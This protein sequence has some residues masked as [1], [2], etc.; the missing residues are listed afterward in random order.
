MLR[1]WLIDN[2]TEKRY[3]TKLKVNDNT[4]QFAQEDKNF[5]KA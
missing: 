1:N 4:W 5:N 3:K 2:K